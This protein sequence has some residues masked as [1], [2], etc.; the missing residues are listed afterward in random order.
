M[1]QLNSYKVA[2]MVKQLDIG[3]GAPIKSKQLDRSNSMDVVARLKERSQANA[4]RKDQQISYE[5]FSRGLLARNSL[6]YFFLYDN[7]NDSC[8]EVEQ[9]L[10]GLE[11]NEKRSRKKSMLP[12]IFRKKE[13]GSENK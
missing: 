10:K 1:P 11:A 5:E 2:K 3:G 8:A 6:L 9:E 12:G 7:K 13:K 4:Q